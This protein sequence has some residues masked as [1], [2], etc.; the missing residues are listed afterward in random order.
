MAQL[1]HIADFM[2]LNPK[3]VDLAVNLIPMDGLT[4]DEVELLVSSAKAQ[5]F[6]APALMPGR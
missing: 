5:E 3:L 1:E 2:A 4:P 6:D